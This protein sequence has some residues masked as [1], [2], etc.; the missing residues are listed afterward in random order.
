MCI[1][2]PLRLKS[3]IFGVGNARKAGTHQIT[4]ASETRPH[5]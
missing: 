5:F 1:F 3:G 4:R 2:H